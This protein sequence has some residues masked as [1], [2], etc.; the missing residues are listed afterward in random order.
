MERKREF[1]NHLEIREF[2]E[3]IAAGIHSGN[4]ELGR[5][6]YT[7]PLMY[8]L[9]Q[10]VH[11]G[12]TKVNAIELGVA[13]GDGLR[14]LCLAAAYLR[15]C[16]PIE[17]DVWG[18]DNA[19]GLPRPR[20]HRDH[21]EI[22]REGDCHMGDPEV[23]GA[24]LPSWAHLIIGDVR[25]TIP[26][27]GRQLEGVLAFVSVDLD[28]YSST[29]DAMEL[30]RFSPECY[31][32][33]LP[34]YF[35]DMDVLLTY[36]EW[37]GEALAIKEFNEAET[38]RKIARKPFGVHNF[39]LCH[40][41]DHPIRTGATPPLFPMEI[42]QFFSHDPSGYIR[43]EIAK[44]WSQAQKRVLI[45][46]AGAHARWVVE[47]T[48]GL[49]NMV[50]GFA[51][52]DPGKQGRTFLDLPVIAPDQIR[53]LAPDV[54]LIASPALEGEIEASLAAIDTGGAEIVRLGALQ[55]AFRV[56]SGQ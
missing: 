24:W 48:R 11:C 32:P 7:L 16:L 21:P 13:G 30:F 2:F 37:C 36:N 52:R 26:A 42:T 50:I 44:A 54:V 35:D 6:Y 17:I 28:F 33:A 38:F 4:L 10:A 5:D 12:Y 3:H 51:D 20:D 40:I 49:K 15:D 9:I 55:S 25:D 41:L 47:H 22:W 31:V 8:G 29:R 46:P 39:H 19:S 1:R 14:A 27:F 53:N 23:V 56:T 43:N 18:F 45:Y 34:M